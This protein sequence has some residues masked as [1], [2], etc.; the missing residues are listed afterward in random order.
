[1]HIPFC[2]LPFYVVTKYFFSFVSVSKFT[3]LINTFMKFAKNMSLI[4]MSKDCFKIFI[5]VRLY[6]SITTRFFHDIQSIMTL[7]SNLF[8]LSLKDIYSSV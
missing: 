5:P 2:Q 3:M 8:T 7:L 4:S 1:M 6:R